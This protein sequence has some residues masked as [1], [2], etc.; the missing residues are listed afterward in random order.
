MSHP[1]LV[2]RQASAKEIARMFLH[3]VAQEHPC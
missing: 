2:E 3:G 1:L